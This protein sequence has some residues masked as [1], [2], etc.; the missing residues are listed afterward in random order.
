MK[1]CIIKHFSTYKNQGKQVI[2]GLFQ[3][4]YVFFINFYH[5]IFRQGVLE[6]L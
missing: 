2:Q 6:Y 1:F 5:R 4:I 3:K